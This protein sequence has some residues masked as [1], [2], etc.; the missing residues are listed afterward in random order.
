MI[1]R[2]RT[3]SESQIMELSLKQREMFLSYQL[4]KN[5]KIERRPLFLEPIPENVPTNAT[6]GRAFTQ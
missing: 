1:R 3:G 4:D 5:K 6:R 2:I